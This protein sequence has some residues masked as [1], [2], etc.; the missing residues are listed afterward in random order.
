MKRLVETPDSVS[1]FHWVLDFPPLSSPSATE[2]LRL[3]GELSLD[4]L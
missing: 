2:R 3:D 4:A 1:V